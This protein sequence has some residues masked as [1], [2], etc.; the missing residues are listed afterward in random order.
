M[1][2][3]NLVCIRIGLRRRP[4][5]GVLLEVYNGKAVVCR[6]GVRYVRDLKRVYPLRV[7]LGD[8]P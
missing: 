1:K 6:N 7:A 2:L 5:W 8:K 3:G 4:V